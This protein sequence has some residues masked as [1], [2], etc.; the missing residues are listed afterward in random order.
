MVDRRGF[1]PRSPACGAG[2]LLNDRAAQKEK[3]VAE[4]GIE[5]TRWR[6]MRPAPSHLATP[7]FVELE[8]WHGVPVLPRSRKVLEAL[9]RMLAPAASKS[10]NGADSRTCTGIAW[11]A[12]R[13][14][15]LE[16]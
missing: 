13:H 12:D 11:L 7:Q 6:L 8:K 1:A 15:A 9:L 2:D 16:R 10:E 5:P 3:M 4:A 14:P